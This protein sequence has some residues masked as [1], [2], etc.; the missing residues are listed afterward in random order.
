L[1]TSFSYTPPLIKD[2]NR[3]TY[4]DT[5]NNIIA[6]HPNSIVYFSSESFVNWASV[7]NSVLGIIASVFTG[8]GYS[9]ELIRQMTEKLRT[10]V[11]FMT[12]FASQT[13]INLG[14]EE[15]VKM[16]TENSTQNLGGY[17]VSVKVVDTPIMIRKCIVNTIA[18]TSDCMPEI[19][20]P[21][22]GFAVIASKENAPY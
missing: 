7:E 20:S 11:T 2:E 6:N 8:G 14:A 3:D 21:R 17:N 9:Q 22:L 16:M 1:V 15:I 13:A 12:V 19:P 18:N 5:K 10:E 4:H